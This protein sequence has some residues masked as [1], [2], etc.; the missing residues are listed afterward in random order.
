MYMNWKSLMRKQHATERVEGEGIRKCLH[1]GIVPE[2]YEGI[3]EG[4]EVAAMREKTVDEQTEMAKPYKTEEAVKEWAAQGYYVR[5]PERDKVYCPG[6]AVL[7]HKS[8]EK[9]RDTRY[10]NKAACKKCPYWNR[11]ITG[12]GQ[13]KEIDFNK[14]TLE[15][16]AKWW[17]ADGSEEPDSTLDG[18]KKRDTTMR[19]RKW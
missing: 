6:G 8:I 18:G 7:R 15:K 14:D 3:I 16:K 5:D 9:N 12:K 10:A 13:W 4:M 2:A 11:C 19:K 1:A 17:E